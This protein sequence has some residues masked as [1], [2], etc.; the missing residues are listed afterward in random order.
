MACVV[1]R[2]DAGA[3]ELPKGISSL[4]SFAGELILLNVHKMS[5][6]LRCSSGLGNC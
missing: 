1:Q 4:K 5:C 2:H 6:S 3:M